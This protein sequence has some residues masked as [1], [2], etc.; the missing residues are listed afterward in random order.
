MSADPEGGRPPGW[1]ERFLSR[2]LAPERAEEVVGD[3][4]EEWRRRPPGPRRSLGHLAAVVS[5]ALHFVAFVARERTRLGWR[6]HLRL[7]I[8][9]LGREPTFAAVVVTATALGIGV[10]VL[11]LSIAE[12][13]LFAPLPY[14]EQD[15][16]AVL[17]NDHSGSS[18]GGF[19]VAYPSI[20][21]VRERARG[22]E[23]VALYLDWQ[24]VTY[25]SADGALQLAA[26]FVSNEY[27]EMLGLETAVGRFFTEEE[28]RE[29]APGSVA[30]LGHGAWTSLFGADRGVLGRTLMLNGRPHEVVGIVDDDRG[31]LR[32]LW[33]QSPVQVYL[34][35]FAV[36]PLVGFDLDADRG[37]RYLNG[38]VRVADGATVQDAEAELGAISGDLARRYPDTNEGWSYALQ[39]L[40]E[41]MYERLRTPTTVVLGISVLVFVL[42][43]V[44][45]VTLVLLRASGRR[46]EDAIRRALGA[47][48]G[49]IFA[50]RLTEGGVLTGL[51]W[52][53]G[54]GLAAWGLRLFSSSGAVRLP[55][56]ATVA[57]DARVLTVT[58]GIAFGLA[59]LLALAPALLRADATGDAE[60]LR[61]G[62]GSRTR[63]RARI[64]GTLVAAEVAV[65]CVLLVGAGFFLGGF[66]ALRDT[67]YGFDTD[68][69]LLARMDVRGADLGVDGLRAFARDL[70]T[71]AERI[72]GVERAFVWSPNRLGY[73]NQVEIVTAE[74]R[75]GVAPEERI[76]ASLHSPHPGTLDAL[77][78]RLMAGR[79]FD[80]SDDPDAPRVALVSESLGAALWPGLDP[81]GRRIETVDGGELVTVEVVGVVSDARHRTRLIEPFEPQRDIYYPF[82]QHA[83][84][85]MTLALRYAD[86]AELAGLA[87]GVRGLVRELSPSS[88]VF[89]V[90]TMAERMREEEGPARLGALLV[91]IYA[92][93]ALSLAAL[94]LYGVLA[95]GVQLQLR[96][97]GIR[98]ALGADRAALVGRVVRRGMAMSLAGMAVG[99]ALA[100][101]G[102]RLLEGMVYGGTDGASLVIAVV[103]GSLTVVAL[104]S[105]AVPA[106]R[107]V[108]IPPSEVL[109]AE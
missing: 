71:R 105:C 109:R 68:R 50:Q 99:T 47:G 101:P 40:D 89:D 63:K 92:V 86:G 12:T 24:D 23:S 15:R 21:D 60:A 34:P 56:F 22:V 36:E 43:A 77:G 13:V 72:P 46:S 80:A 55:E 35:L 52:I 82:A 94:G 37:R 74:G 9:R 87:N 38:L 10:N 91:G 65:A 66:R 51:G 31:D 16:L 69:L 30:V 96:E 67:G 18:T 25:A 83:S 28:N 85:V 93:L 29:N 100:L 7:S 53:A 44:N 95:H 73:G 75:W 20:R 4:R 59:V 45:L 64:Q 102:I 57:L 41:A 104:V 48:R 79:G 8:R 19:G 5:V 61:G 39:R 97:I 27:V 78:I 54:T 14:P 81:L 49:R 90:T 26:A 6:Q 58:A 62:R 32:Y 108:R 3:L 1:T 70:T 84:G 2:V 107:A 17:T 88:P 42:V 98:M 33:G 103:L 11:M 76:E 106:G